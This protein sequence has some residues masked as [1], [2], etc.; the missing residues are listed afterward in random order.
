[1]GGTDMW[2]MRDC[3]LFARVGT[4]FECFDHGY[5]LAWPRNPLSRWSLSPSSWVTCC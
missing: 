2:G 5:T 1:M 3:S 4:L